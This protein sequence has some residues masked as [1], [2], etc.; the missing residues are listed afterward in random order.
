MRRIALITFFVQIILLFSCQASPESRP[1][2][3]ADFFNLFYSPALGFMQESFASCISSTGTIAPHLREQFT[4]TDRIQSS[5]MI[6]TL[7][8]TDWCD[9]DCFITQIGN[10]KIVFIINESNFE[11][12]SNMIGLT[13]ILSGRRTH[14]QSSPAN[15]REITL[16]VYPD[17][18]DLMKWL[19]NGF[20]K[21]SKLSLKTKIVPHPG[22]MLEAVSRDPNSIGFLPESWLDFSDPQLSNKIKIVSIVDAEEVKMTLPILAYLTEKPSGG[23]R[24][25]L[26]CLKDQ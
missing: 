5:D 20:L 7:G 9:T 12:T 6:L 15:E 19:E 18:S 14:W 10:E 2:P 23:I 13:E 25:F 24:E 3:T 8:E 26:L 17:G 16:W 11:D 22:A 4:A 1:I 21:V